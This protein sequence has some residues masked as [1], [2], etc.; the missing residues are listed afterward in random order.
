MELDNV[1]VENQTLSAMISDNERHMNGLA[2]HLE[3][4]ATN[5]Y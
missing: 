5:T 3:K 4:D 2:L 1:K